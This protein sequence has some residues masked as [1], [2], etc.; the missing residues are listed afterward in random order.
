[1]NILKNKHTKILTLFMAFALVMGCVTI[2]SP[3]PVHADD[4]IPVKIMED[5]VPYQLFSE[6]RTAYSNSSRTE[7]CTA[8]Y[9]SAHYDLSKVKKMKSSFGASPSNWA[10][11][12]GNNGGWYDKNGVAITEL[13]Q[14]DVEINVEAIARNR[15]LTDCYYYA[16]VT[17]NIENLWPD[18]PLA[19]TQHY[20]CVTV[21]ATVTITEGLPRAPKFTSNLPTLKTVQE[22]KDMTLQVQGTNYEEAE[23]QVLT[24]LGGLLSYPMWVTAENL[25]GMEQYKDRVSIETTSGYSTL[26]LSNVETVDAGMQFKVTLKKAGMDSATSDVCELSVVPGGFK[27]IEAIATKTTM[28][29]GDYLTGA[30]LSAN[31]K[32]NVYALLK[33][34]D[35]Q[36]IVL[37]IASLGNVYMLSQ[38]A[39]EPEMFNSDGSLKEEYLTVKQA[40]Q[41]GDHTY[42]LVFDNAG[43]QY[44]GKNSAGDASLAI[45]AENDE[46]Q[47]FVANSTASS[48]QWQYS[49]NGSTWQ[50]CVEGSPYAGTTT[51]YLT[52]PSL[53]KEMNGYKFKCLVGG[54]AAT[55]IPLTVNDRYF[56]S[57]FNV[58][59]IDTSAPV[60]D[61]MYG[62]WISGTHAGEQYVYGE[63]DTVTN[64]S[65]ASL[66]LHV[67]ASDNVSAEDRITYEW[68]KVGGV[69]ALSSGT[70]NAGNGNECI[71]YADIRSNGTYYCV[72]KDENG[73]TTDIEKTTFKVFAFDTVAP[74]AS[75]EMTTDQGKADPNGSEPAI[76]KELTINAF[77]TEDNATR[78]SDFFLADDYCLVTRE[79]IDVN[80]SE[81]LSH[82]IWTQ[83]NSYVLTENGTYYVFIRD[84]AGNISRYPITVS[85][86]DRTAPS[87]TDVVIEK[88]DATDVEVPILGEDGNPVYEDV[89]DE[90]GNPVYEDVL[91]SDGNP[92]Y[93][94]ALDENGN[95][96]YDDV[97]DENGD[98]IYDYDLDEDGNRI[99]D[100]DADGNPAFDEEGNPIYKKHVR[101][102]KRQQVKQQIKKKAKTKTE[103]KNSA[104]I[105]VTADDDTNLL[106]KIE[107]T[108]SDNNTTTLTRDEWGTNV[109]G[110]YDNGGRFTGLTEDGVY[111][112]YVKDGAGNVSKYSTEYVKIT[113]VNGG[114]GTGFFDSDEGIEANIFAYPQNATNGNVQINISVGNP[115]L[116]S[117]TEP[118]SFDGINFS[119]TPQWTVTQNGIYH[120]WVKDTYDNIYKSND[121]TINNIDK[122]LP[123]VTSAS[124][125][126]KNNVINVVVNDEGTSGLDILKYKEPGSNEWRGLKSWGDFVSTSEAALVVD[127]EGTYSFKV[128]D[129]AGNASSSYDITVSNSRPNNTILDNDD[130]ETIAASISACITLSPTSWTKD[131]VTATVSLAD[132]NDLASMPYSWDGGLTWTGK[133]THTFT[134]N[135]A[136]YKLLVKD[137]YGHAYESKPII[138]NNI[139]KTAPSV[140][141][142]A[143]GTNDL[144]ISAT[145]LLSGVAKIQ[146]MGGTI[147]TFTPLAVPNNGQDVCTVTAHFPCNGS[148]TI[149][150]YDVAGNK[151]TRTYT[152]TAYVAPKDDSKSNNSNNNSGSGNNN[153]GG[154]TPPSNTSTTTNNYYYGNGSGT[155]TGTTTPTVS[156]P[157]TTTASKT[158]TTTPAT[159]TAGTTTTASKKTTATT[160]TPA[161]SAKKITTD[162]TT[163]K[164]VT[165][166]TDEEDVEILDEENLAKYRNSRISGAVNATND[167]N[168]KGGVNV[169]LG[170]IGSLTALSAI[171][172]GVYYYVAKYKPRLATSELS[173]DDEFAEDIAIEQEQK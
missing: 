149:E 162:V 128:Y 106:F 66:K 156:T 173:D 118:F 8:S 83:K 113:L 5:E 26:T 63:H 43:N 40:V 109:D 112:V 91:N 90:N 102:K 15:D 1:M 10:T 124:T 157:L 9:T 20:R 138:I 14:N 38:S 77:D 160:T 125:N 136:D 56:T 146:W 104:N 88:G 94:D 76:Y 69:S 86:I 27:S 44:V 159:T 73:N 64:D 108:D 107:R 17:A 133:Q 95:P 158:T 60:V 78:S 121:I 53:T 16:W 116:L 57:V 97:L 80:D 35:S 46:L 37:D 140:T 120:V 67:K 117:S 52:I 147:T 132:M 59:G 153:G 23:W 152:E 33:Y 68:W 49:A 89:L 111:T 55:E 2:S 122:V 47:L 30:N 110:W 65:V 61:E 169:V 100:E 154:G 93:E 39:L 98:A 48:Y 34:T 82:C 18:E 12:T 6:S 144:V 45:G 92:V 24:D 11:V 142:S 84:A 123:V 103:R 58:T 42:M 171:A 172:A 119:T 22:G 134:E 32:A 71:L 167:A 4:V 99:Q 96:I 7:S 114:L 155:N 139:D 148:Y 129:K 81:H 28:E 131:S 13:N 21:S 127:N 135:S 101:Q 75:F 87:I 151:V 50:D 105:I 3:L 161:T 54:T 72:I 168:K 29:I 143:S 25:N 41:S 145:D 62:E 164:P 36:K 85:G 150:V 74:I 141:L 51:Q 126:A 79:N 166:S 19:N 170:I 31:E 165:T 70:I 137:C 130:P 115:S 163:A